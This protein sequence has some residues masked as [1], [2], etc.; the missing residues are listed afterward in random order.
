MRKR[1][2]QGFKSLEEA[3]GR[4]TE[5]SED[6]GLKYGYGFYPEAIQEMPDGTFQF[7]WW[8]GSSCD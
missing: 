2:A 8:T 1:V 6:P 3:Q 4:R 7:V 5:L